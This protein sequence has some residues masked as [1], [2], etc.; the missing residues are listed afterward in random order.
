MSVKYA[1]LKV[2]IAGLRVL[3][4]PMKLQKTKNRIT[5]ISRQSDKE[6]VDVKLLRECLEAEY[7]NVECVVMTK[8]IGEGIGGKI[9]YGFDILRQMKNIAVSKVVIIDG[10]CIAVSVLNHKPETKVIQMWH[11]MAAIKK[12]GHQTLDKQAGHSSRLAEIMCMH[13]NYDYVL[14]PGEETGRL[15]CKGFNTG[16]D[17]LKVMALPRVDYITAGDGNTLNKIAEI[18]DSLRDMAGDREVILYAPTFRKDGQV[19]FKEL[20]EAL[21]FDRFFLV[22][23]PHPLDANTYR[24]ELG[25]ADDSAAAGDSTATGGSNV[26][27]DTKERTLTWLKICDRVITDYSAVA[28]E[29]LVTGKPLY[30]YVYDIDEYKQNV[31]LNVNPLEELPGCSATDAQQLADMILQEYD[32]ASL[33]RFKE[34]YLTADTTGCT[35]KLADFAVSL[36]E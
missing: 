17:T 2:G 29:T 34:K 22:V 18:K 14:C 33:G 20:V 15:F 25:Q 30:F 10:Y 28:V 13:R 26:M 7:P 23:R 24:Q 21:D 11:A 4:G 36:C 16:A 9:G 5:I 31:G 3:Y 6:T 32:F 1:V 27:V 19:Q 12:F 35:K 8:K